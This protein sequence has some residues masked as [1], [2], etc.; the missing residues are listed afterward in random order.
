MQAPT[1]TRSSTIQVPIGPTNPTIF[2]RNPIWPYII[3]YISLPISPYI[4]SLKG[5]G[6]KEEKAV[7]FKAL[8]TA[9]G[10]QVLGSAARDH[11]SKDYQI[12]VLWMMQ[13]LGKLPQHW[14]SKW[15]RI[16][17]MTPKPL[18]PNPKPYCWCA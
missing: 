8:E 16:L 15:K 18:N 13:G 5:K 9:W 2:L 3:I 14:R 6:S 11:N 10:C 7:C 12:W 4:C 17:I 1:G